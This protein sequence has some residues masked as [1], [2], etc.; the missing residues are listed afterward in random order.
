MSDCMQVDFPI[1]PEFLSFYELYLE[2]TRMTWR[3]EE[4][5]GSNDRHAFM[6]VHPEVK[7]L[8]HVMLKMLERVDN[9]VGA[10]WTEI[11]PENIRK[12]FIIDSIKIYIEYIEREH[13]FTYKKF[14]TEFI[15]DPVK[16]A[17]MFSSFMTFGPIQ[18]LSQYSERYIKNKEY[19]YGLAANMLIEHVLLPM[20]FAFVGWT[21]DMTLDT[22]IR[23]V[24]GFIQANTFVMKDEATHARFAFML[25]KKFP[26]LLPPESE[27][28]RLCLEFMQFVEDFNSEAFGDLNLQGINSHTLNNIARCQIND[29]LD[30]M[31]PNN[32]GSLFKDIDPL[33][34]YMLSSNVSKKESNF[35]LNSVNYTKPGVADWANAPKNP[36]EK[37][38]KR[39]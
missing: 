15:D 33:P 14:I 39:V 35:E 23:R 26:E 5:L 11:V 18:R 20:I 8:Y 25:I 29:A 19:K 13:A 4:V 17:E 32:S 7:K 37:K 12:V 3:H 6:N 38:N 27:M 36:L 30:K 34:G 28:R 16:R 24:P 2:M 21:A 10:N 1:D 22:M 31:Y 9:I